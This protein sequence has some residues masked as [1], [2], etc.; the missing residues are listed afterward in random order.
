MRILATIAISF[1]AA[2][3]AAVL[4]PFSGWT[5]MAGLILAG[6]GLVCLLVKRIFRTQRK[7]RKLWLRLALISLATAAALLYF[8]VYHARV[9][10]PLRA[11]CGMEQEFSAT[12]ADFPEETNYGGKV[13][14]SLPHG[15][16]AMYYGQKDVLDLRPGEKISGVARWQDASQI[17]GK[18]LTAFTS[19]GVYVLLYG[20]D[21]LSVTEGS[22]GSIRWWPLHVCRAVQEKIHAIWPDDRTAAFVC[23]ILTG[24]RSGMD[25]ADAAAVEEV[26]LSH[27]F[28][29]SGL[30][31]AFL[32]TMLGLLL[33]RHRRR[34]FAGCSIAVLLFYMT[35]V[36]LKPSVV[37]SCIMLLFYEIAPL[38]HRDSDGL[39]SWSCALLVLLLANPYAA[40]SVSLQLSFAATGGL[41]LCAGRMY[42]R[43]MQLSVPKG[44]ARRLWSFFAANISTTLGALLFT[45]PLT[46]YYFGLLTLVAPLSGLLVLPVASWMFML[47]FVLVLVGFVCLPLAQIGGWAVW[48]MVHYALGVARVLMRLPFHAVYFTNP[49]LRYWLMYCYAMLLTC[50]LTHGSRWKYVLTTVLA[51]AALGVTVH[52]GEAEYRTEEMQVMTLDVGQGECVLLTQGENA[53]L[54]DCGSGNSYVSAGEQAAHQLHTMGIHRLRA[55]AVTHYDSDHINGLAGL[56]ARI[57]VETLYLPPD[58]GEVE[59]AVRTMAAQYGSKVVCVDTVRD[60]A[61]GS[62]QIRIYPPVGQGGS[63]E[64]GLTVLSSAG[65]FDVL[66]PGDMGG[67][68]E[69]KFIEAWD[70][71]E[72]EVLLVGHHG[73][74]YSS[75]MDFLQAVQPQTAIISVGDNSFSH[76]AAEAINRLALAGATVY[77]TDLQGNILVTVHEGD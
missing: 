34:L 62:D 40:A 17:H 71:P 64:Q 7:R 74:K 26:G 30:H 57:P 72:I 60:F 25:E 10:A 50:M 59:A 31:C 75:T 12:V 54:V 14:V 9:V 69:R 33:P 13:I 73:S 38:F 68:T 23:A 53:M 49:Y 45:I 52:L 11:V 32:V 67:S 5:H 15:G 3:F 47:S 35:M 55:A 76:P 21:R 66:I 63:N 27:L 44:L 29:V 61:L 58:G 19:R 16:K 43:M 24:E 37:R 4:L 20:Q 1:A 42:E 48:A 22:A 28:A 77:R 65:T 41:L 70:L 6:V 51:V 18:P 46:G 36:G 2:I 8:D 56:L 39:T